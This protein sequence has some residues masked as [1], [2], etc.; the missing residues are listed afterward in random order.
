MPAFLEAKLR[1]EASAK[2]KTGAAADRY[3]FGTLNSI[4]AMKGSKETAKGKSM[5]NTHLRDM[6]AKR[7]GGK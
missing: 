3:V 7:S 4:G 1:K 6:L 2:G 5:E